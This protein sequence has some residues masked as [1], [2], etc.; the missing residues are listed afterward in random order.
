MPQ[1]S[2]AKYPEP[3]ISRPALPPEYGIQGPAEGKGL[4][5]W[6]WAVERLTQARGYWL[7]TTRPDGRPHLAV[8]WASGCAT[9]S[10][11]GR[12]TIRARG[13]ISQLIP[14]APSA[15]NKRLRRSLWRVSPNE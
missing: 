2:D 10:T 9:D 7:A 6:N 15:R 3:E 12:V 8:I 1:M 14:I 4:L 11:L 13:E 5:P